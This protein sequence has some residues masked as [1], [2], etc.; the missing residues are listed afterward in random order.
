MKK[1]WW[2][3]IWVL[4]IAALLYLVLKDINFYEVYLLLG[5]ANPYYISLAVLCTFMTFI[6][7]GIRWTYLFAKIFRRDFWFLLNV[8]LAGAFFN[9]ITPGAGI[10]GEPFRAHF[11]A[12][13]YKKSETEMLGYVMAD[14]FYQLIVLAAL[15]VFSV[16]FV[17]AYVQIS[18]TLK[19][20]LEGILIFVLA[21]A[22]IAVYL[23]LKKL[24]FNIGAFVKR[25]H[26]LKF[27]KKHFKH[28]EHFE[29]FVNEKIRIFSQV[30]RKSV[31]N[32]KHM[33]EA[34]FL[35]IVF[36]GFQFLTSYFLFLAFNYPVN[37]LSVVIVITLGS[38]IGSL[39]M[40]PGGIGFTEISMALL[41]SA[42]GIAMP[43]ALLVAFFSRLIYYFF[44]L[45]IGGL[46]LIHIRK[47][48]NGKQ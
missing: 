31:K 3:L 14:K 45:P 22:G 2:G 11:L 23:T 6:V 16:I 19:Y 9:T 13:R 18:N 28:P 40:V 27:V 48:V 39:A 25:F 4:V 47:V 38:L 5:Y 29:N 36:W 33:F 20:V 44:S 8:L 30:F 12:K 41:F 15:A 1:K 21:F 35:A 42:M 32:K 26:R 37:F 24:N 7:W 17:L 34:F 43:L 46:S 10:G